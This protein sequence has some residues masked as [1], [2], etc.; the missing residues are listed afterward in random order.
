MGGST[1]SRA[2]PG[3]RVR[4]GFTLI[5]LVVII[6]ILG[7]LAGVAGPRFF[8][9]QSFDERITRDELAGSLR[10]AG[11]LALATGC[12]V[13]VQVTSN[14]WDLHQRTGCSSG[15]FTQDVVDPTNGGSEYQVRPAGA[16]TVS[17]TA[18]TLI[19]DERGQSVDGSGALQSVTLTA[20]THTVQVV[21]ATGYV[22]TP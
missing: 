20:G 14:R 1:N 8:R 18:S 6:A 15:A 3:A 7:I 4:R 22:R 10:Y 19:F 11:K 21:G 9:R 16:V 12:E 2:A 13:E 17:T 5:E